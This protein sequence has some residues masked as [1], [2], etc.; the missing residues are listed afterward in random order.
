MRDDPVRLK[1]LRSDC[2][3]VTTIEYG[4]IAAF[5]AAVLVSIFGAF[6]SSLSFT[7]TKIDTTLKAPP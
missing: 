2:H 1:E 4:L 5:M 6:G 3:G 7:F